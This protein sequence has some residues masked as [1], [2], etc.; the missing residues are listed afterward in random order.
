M[1]EI[2]NCVVPTNPMHVYKDIN[3]GCYKYVIKY[4]MIYK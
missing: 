1:S 2:I 3:V 4:L